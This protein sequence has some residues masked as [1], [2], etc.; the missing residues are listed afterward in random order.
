MSQVRPFLFLIAAL[1]TVLPQIEAASPHFPTSEDLRHLG[2]IGSPRLS[3]DGK[4]VLLQ[5]SE[6]TADGAKA[7]IWLVDIETDKARQLTFSPDTD[8]RG[9]HNAAWTPDGASILF[10]AHRGEHTQLFRLPMNGGEAKAFEIKTAPPVD[11]SKLPD[12]LPPASDDKTKKDAAPEDKSKADT[13]PLDIGSFDISPDGKTIAILADDPETPGEKK[14]GEDKAD[15]TWVDHDIHGTRLYLFDIA[16]GKL[17][18][19]TAPIDVRIATWSRDSARLVVLTDE[20]HNMS[21]LHPSGAAWTLTAAD[22][23]QVEKLDTL[24]PTIEAAT[25]SVDGKSIDFLAQAKQDSPPG[26]TDLY[27]YDVATKHVSNRTDGFTGSIG[28]GEPVSLLDG[29]T[30]QAV[31]QGISSTVAIVGPDDSAPRLL[32]FASPVVGSLDTNE[33]QTAWVYLEQGGAQPAALYYTTRLD[34]PARLLHTPPV[35]PKVSTQSPRNFFTGRAMASPLKDFCICPR[36]PKPRRCLW[37]SMCMAARSARSKTD[38]IRSFSSCSATAGPF[39]ARILGAARITA[40]IS[41][42]P[43][44]MTS[45]EA[46]TA[47]LWP[48]SITRSRT[49]TLIQTGWR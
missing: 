39:S 40:R 48:A 47:T 37:W 21:D 25:W 1:L 35:G 29:T 38:M 33:Q 30:L 31:S 41:P 2:S 43:I 11:R 36:K 19:T 12:A 16:T 34:Q 24:P 10:L 15:A 26:Y 45:A 49:Q 7:H 13:L 9:E 20:P 22:P 17:T 18:L 42:P 44:R 14:Q 6:S 5:V 4:T 46:T 32:H 8:K 27:R 28:Y 23:G 3:P